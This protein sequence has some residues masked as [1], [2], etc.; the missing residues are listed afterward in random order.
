[1]QAEAIVSDYK[2]SFNLSGLLQE[3]KNVTKASPSEPKGLNGGDL[4]MTVRILDILVNNSKVDNTTDNDQQN[5]MEICSNILEPVN[6]KPWI[7]FENQR[8]KVYS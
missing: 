4:E 2:P 5:F 1:M 7:Q 8:R 6:A 3:L